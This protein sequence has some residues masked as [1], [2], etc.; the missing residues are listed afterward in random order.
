MQTTNFKEPAPAP[1]YR[2]RWPWLIMLGPFLVVLAGGYTIWLAY[3]S[4]DAL[5][6]GDYYKQGKAIN[7][8]LTRDSAAARLGLQFAL[9]YD[10]ASGR[11]LGRVSGAGTA[12]QGPMTLKLIHS[13][14]PEKDILL[15]LVADAEG[16]VTA[17]LPMLDMARW[18]VVLED[19]ERTWRVSGVWPWPQQTAVALSAGQP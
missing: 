7:R 16:N 1:W 14:R 5:V 10:A 12:V 8:D 2:H 9:R 15:P 19:Q 4:Q 6:V 3:S 11:L 18:Q 17:S 13:T